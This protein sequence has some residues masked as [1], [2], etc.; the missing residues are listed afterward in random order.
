[1]AIITT[2]VVT[3]PEYTGTSCTYRDAATLIDCELADAEEGHSI[4]I[5]PKKMTVEA[6]ESLPEF[7]G[8]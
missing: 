1:M 3:R 4:V 5:T 7:E 8:W 2:Y 6:L